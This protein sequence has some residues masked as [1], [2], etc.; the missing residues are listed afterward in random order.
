MTTAGQAREEE[1][2]SS[3]MINFIKA[4]R[5]NETTSTSVLHR[6]LDKILNSYYF[7]ARSALNIEIERTNVTQSVRPSRQLSSLLIS[8]RDQRRPAHSFEFAEFEC[9][10]LWPHH[11]LQVNCSYEQV[12]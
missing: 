2:V 4:F 5:S 12:S 11:L 1:R 10:Y 9:L 8:N 6:G 3:I 7:F